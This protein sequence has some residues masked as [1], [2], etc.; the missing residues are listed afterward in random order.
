MEPTKPTETESKVTPIIKEI[1]DL[2]SPAIDTSKKDEIN[3]FLE[4]TINGDSIEDSLIMNAGLGNNKTGALVYILTNKSLIRL[5]LE[6]SG[7][8][9]SSSFKIDAIVEVSRK[10]DDGIV[11]V[12]VSFQDNK[13]IGL[14]YSMSRNDIT[15]FF[16]KID[17]GQ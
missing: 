9:E 5:S 2:K 16:Q 6:A 10:L 15:E 7:D 14:K 4:I 13:S 17:R 1:F 11:Q 12:N 8:I 3:K